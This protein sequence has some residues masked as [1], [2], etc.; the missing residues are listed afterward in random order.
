MEELVQ[1][2]LSTKVDRLLVLVGLA[3]VALGLV[4]DIEGRIRPGRAGRIAALVFG[5][6]LLG[7]GAGLHFRDPGQ[8]R[9]RGPRGRAE[10]AAV[11]G[12]GA[13]EPRATLDRQRSPGAAAATLDGGARDGAGRDDSRRDRRGEGR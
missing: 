6:L 12:R 1:Q 5:L 9:D 7:T 11:S 4:G 13:P 2:L 10:P 3:F 8:P